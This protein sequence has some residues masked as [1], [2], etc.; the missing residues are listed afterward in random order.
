MM[1]KE[2]PECG[3]IASMSAPDPSEAPIM[4]S[5]QLTEHLTFGLIEC[6][7]FTD[8]EAEAQT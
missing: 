2:Y 7:H 4:S 1:S 3:P 8:E 6:F 5:R